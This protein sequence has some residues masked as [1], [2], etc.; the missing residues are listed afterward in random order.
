MVV[1]TAEWVPLTPT[2]PVVLMGERDNK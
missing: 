2:Q 1:V